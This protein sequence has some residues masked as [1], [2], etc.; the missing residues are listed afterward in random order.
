ML[1]FH[2]DIIYPVRK[3]IVLL[4]FQ[5]QEWM[6]TYIKQFGNYKVESEI[7]LNKTL[8]IYMIIK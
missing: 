3:I 2:A 7:L 4:E 1:K 8:G 5:N 6:P